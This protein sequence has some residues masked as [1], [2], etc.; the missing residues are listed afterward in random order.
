MEVINY[1]TSDKK[2]HWLG[3]IQKSVWGAGKYLYELLSDHKLKGLCGESTMVFLLVEG[4]ELLSFCTYA[5]QDEVR[6]PSLTPWVGFV[7]TFPEHRGKR[8]V[9]NLLKKAYDLAKNYGH[10]YIYISTGETGLYE[11]YGYSFWKMMKNVEGGDS[12]VYRIEIV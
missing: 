8:L 5:E 6:E 4:D 2:D 1:F 3:E 9:G 10:K 7:Y 11:K 12:R